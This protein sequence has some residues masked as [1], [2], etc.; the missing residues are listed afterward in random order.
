[1]RNAFV[2]ALAAL[3][4]TM[5]ALAAQDPAKQE[6]GVETFQEM[7]NPKVEAHD[8]LKPLAGT[9]QCTIKM[10]AIPGVPG[11]EK[12]NELTSMEHAELVCGGLWLKSSVRGTFMGQPFQGV[13]LAGYDPLQKEYVSLWVDN[14]D[15]AMAEMLGS[16][17]P[18][19]K[20]WSW[21]GE[22]SMGAMRSKMVWKDADTTVE[23]CW[24]TPPDA[25]EMQTMEI[26]RKRVAPGTAIAT[27]AAAPKGAAELS[28]GLR[29]LHRG[30]GAWDATVKIAMDAAGVQA[31]EKC[32]EHVRPICDGKY[33]WSDFAG[34]MMGL[35]FE[36]HALVGFDAAKGEYVSYW[37]DS[38]SATWMKTTGKLDPES[39]SI[40]MH[41]TSLDPDGSPVKVR[42][43]MSWEGDDTRLLKME[44][45]GAQGTQQMEIVYRRAAKKR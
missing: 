45:E 42:E 3:S 33:T 21:S 23:T 19:S 30:L 25:D 7:P 22:S 34:T 15:P 4:A 27:E 18:E 36:G 24:S 1:M 31:E 32:T 12:P 35:P 5:C 11:M 2:S 20:T 44:F 16:Y 29:E 41:G 13:W 38:M 39:K 37:I 40:T 9:W 43:V 8:A 28:A 14:H 17:D 10:A 26:T 6:A